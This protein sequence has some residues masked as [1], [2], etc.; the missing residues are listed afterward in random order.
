MTF[1]KTF[2]QRGFFHQCTHEDELEAIMNRETI[3]GYIGFDCTAT[4]LHAGSLMQIMIL[5]MLQQHGH[6][7]IV[8]LG[9]GT[10]RIG[11]PSGK[12]QA[13]KMLTDDAIATNMAGIQS[14]LEKYITFGDGPTD[15]MLVNNAD[16]LSNLKYL[17]F[18]R[19][20]GPHFSINRMLT[21]DSVK[22][23]LER[24]Q[25]LSFLEFNYMLLQAYDFVELHK[26]HHCRIQFGGSDQW[27][28]II[29]GV[30]LGRRLGL[31][32][33]YGVT[34]PL[35][36]TASGAKMG[37]TADGAIWLSEDLLSPYDYWQY[38]R[39]TDD[40]DVG[41]FLRYFTE[42]PEEEINRLELLEGE[43]INDAKKILAT[44]VTALCHGREAAKRAEE[45]AYQTFVNQASGD[46]LPTYEIDATML[47][48][49]ISLFELLKLSGL[50]AS[51][52]EARKLIRGG[53]A[54]IDGEPCKDELFKISHEHFE[55]DTIKLSSG[56]KKHVIIKKKS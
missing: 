4:S 21:M 47:Q 52:G 14:V 44:E 56:K 25:N 16:W 18:L 26:T 51:G 38:W 24:E 5:R 7:P 34:T 41:S 40:R 15:A 29:S 36:T 31:K 11:D 13:R 49:G 55:S 20:I 53:G 42:L 9:G 6:K 37:K 30:E 48:E 2:K 27:G 54:R 3:A 43:E 1:L 32:E 8:L 45:T 35:L 12:D 19:D 50:C 28:N 23:R 17:D 46:D 22:L 33:L 10:T 39:N